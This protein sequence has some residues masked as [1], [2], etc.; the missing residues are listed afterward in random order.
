MA[1]FS[2]MTVVYI[3]RL[4][5]RGR[6]ISLFI[7]FLGFIFF[8]FGILHLLGAFTGLDALADTFGR[9][10]PYLLIVSAG[11]ADSRVQQTV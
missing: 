1:V 9:S 8:F 7:N 3:N 11:Y 6:V 10:I 2:G 5:H 4:D